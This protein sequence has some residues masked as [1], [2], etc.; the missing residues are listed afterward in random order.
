MTSQVKRV[1]A[2]LI[3]LLAGASLAANAASG[4][5]VDA[6][7]RKPIPGAIVVAGEH[8]AMTAKDGSF[9][10][11]DIGAQVA[12]LTVKAPGF[13]R[14]AVPMAQPGENGMVVT[15]TAFRPK[16]VYLSAYGVASRTLLAA[17]LALTDT[18]VI[19]A[20]VIDLKGDRGVTPYRSPA[21]EHIGAQAYVPRNAPHIADLPGLVTM[22]HAR[23]LYL[24]ARIVVFKDDPFAQAHPEWAVRN[25]H[26]DVWCDREQLRW[27]DPTLPVVWSHNLDLAEEAA[28]M[29]FDEIQFDYL[30]FPDA[31]GLRFH[32]PNTEA[33]RV[34]AIT[35]FLDA[36]HERLTRYGV[37]TSVD[38]F[39]YVC[40]NLNDTDIGQQLETFGARVD[41]ISPMLYPSG[42]T[43]G[44]PGCRKPTEHA[45]EIV[46]RSLSE[47]IRRSGLPGVRFRPWL[48]AFRDY[49]FDHKAFG[50]VEIQAQ[51][52]AAESEQTDGW[53]L[54]NPRNQYDHDALLR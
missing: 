29:G 8:M 9:S 4:M 20:L 44:L 46:A 30:R 35:G 37:Y 45:G 23:G 28:R 47:A 40:W 6:R 17:A 49:A 13:L 5:V 34:A 48:Q 18:T 7:T 19:N 43:W 50:P 26:G 42:F 3:C 54:W 53:M 32:E 15:M 2:I 24:I 22:L 39:G 52:K 27:L 25:A 14:V 31:A 36:A 38:I 10:I 33:H 16:A 1:G 21:R 11:S 41:Y 12:T 51:I